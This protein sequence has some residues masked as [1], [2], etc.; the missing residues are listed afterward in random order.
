[1]FGRELLKR[2][3]MK[4]IGNGMDTSVWI[5]KWIMDDKPRRPIN[6][7]TFMDLNLKVSNLIG[8]DG[9]WCKLR[10]DVMFPVEDVNRIMDILVSDVNKDSRSWPYTK[11]GVYAVK[12]GYAFL[13]K[14]RDLHLSK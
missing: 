4:N 3:V 2:G 13:E 10:L 1:M 9:R 7:E 11:N 12:S 8:E 5:D 14:E 6:K